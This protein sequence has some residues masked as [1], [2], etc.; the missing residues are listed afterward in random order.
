MN[1]MMVALTLAALAG[2]EGSSVSPGTVQGNVQ[3]ARET[4]AAAL[5]PSAMTWQEIDSLCTAGKV[6]TPGQICGF[7]R[8]PDPKMC[9]DSYLE[10]VGRPP[11]RDPRVVLPCADDPRCR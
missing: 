11:R 9:T 8:V 7:G 4:V 6:C 2:C 1:R 10:S 3:G 5:K